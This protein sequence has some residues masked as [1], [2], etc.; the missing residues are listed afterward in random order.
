VGLVNHHQREVN[1]V[2]IHFLA[3][4]VLQHARTN[5]GISFLLK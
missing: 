5:D 4:V 1:K 2:F 3:D